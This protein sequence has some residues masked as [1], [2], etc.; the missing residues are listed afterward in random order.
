MTVT[1]A[2]NGEELSREGFERL[3]ADLS[4]IFINLSADQIEASVVGGLGRIAA[5]F[6][7]ER[8]TLYELSETKTELTAATWA[9]DGA[10]PAPVIALADD[11]CRR[12]MLLERA[13]VISASDPAEFPDVWA[14]SVPLTIG[15]ES[16]G[17]LE[18]ASTTRQ[19]P[20]TDDLAGE[21]TSLAEIFSNAVMR[22]R[23]ARAL[24][25][26]SSE[27]QN[28]R[29]GAR[30]RE[31]R[32]NLV[33]D[34]APVMIWMSDTG[35]LCAYVNKPWLDFVGR[36]LSAELGNGWA[37]GIHAA[38]RP[39]RLE[40]YARAFDRRDR[41]TMQYRHRRYD[42]EYRWLLATGVPRFDRHGSFDGYIGSCIDITNERLAEE[43]LTTLG[44]RLMEA[45][46]QER[47]RIARDLHDDI[48]Q[49]LAVLAIELQQPNG[50]SL[51][52]IQR[53]SEELVNRTVGILIDVQALTHE[54]H[55]SKLEFLGI[56][57]AIRGFC[58]EF[59][60]QQQ[61]ATIDFTFSSV[62]ADLPQ[63]V[64][65]CLFRALQEALRNAVKHSG[66]QH[67]EVQLH[68]TSTSI[69]LTVRDRGRGFNPEVAMRGNSLGLVSMRE[70]VNRVKGAIQV[71]SKPGWG[72]EINICIP[73]DANPERRGKTHDA[74]K[75]V[76]LIPSDRAS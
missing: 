29:T 47:S 26:A 38:D 33:A 19:L 7:V 72:T 18:M 4:A 12:A 51:A 35:G 9:Q 55:S 23:T 34:T 3:R 5:F 71:T 21:L 53:R 75:R 67:V 63:G 70:R 27:L 31:E 56:V 60:Q 42:G 8:A 41:F 65:L 40:T 49:R 2:G 15:G 28:A 32:F 39:A 17:A 11:R 22:A 36:P 54:L 59:S 48:C 66:V 52:D 64:S 30:E 69:L 73:I 62:P 37:D 20:W 43:A 58:V 1:V 46:E 6:G 44:G 50:D 25:A 14:A 76:Y 13:G 24:L 74:S 16:I 68:G 45:Q 57:A 61:A 10:Y